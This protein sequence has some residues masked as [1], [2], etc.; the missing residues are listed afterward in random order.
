MSDFMMGKKTDAKKD[1]CVIYKH[2]IYLYMIFYL[3]EMEEHNLNKWKI[4]KYVLLLEHFKFS[5]KLI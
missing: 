4:V 2:K 1:I 3:E 5:F